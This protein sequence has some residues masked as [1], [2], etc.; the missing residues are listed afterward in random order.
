MSGILDK[1]QLALQTYLCAARALPA[2][3][4]PEAVRAIQNRKL[5]SLLMH[6]YNSTKYYR[7][8]FDNAGVKPT[9]IR[10]AD[11]LP[12]IPPLTR[13]DLRG[14]FWDFLPPELPACRVSRTSGSTGAPVCILSDRNS[15]MFNSAAVIR[16]RR[17]AGIPLIGTPI[18]TPLKTAEQGRKEP[19]WTFL[20]GLH[21][22]YYVN[23]YLDSPSY[24]ESAAKLLTTIRHPVLIGITPAI[25]AL[26]YKVRNKVLPAFQPLA[27]V[28]TGEILSLE[29]R[30]LLESTFT[31]KVFD[32]YSCNE[33]GD[34]AWQ[35]RCGQGYHINADNCIVEILKDGKPAGPGEIGEVVIT[36]LN[37]YSMPIIRY[38]NGDLA[39]LATEPCPCGC[40]LPML[41]EIIG[42]T[43]QD[44]ICPDGKTIAWNQL[45]TPAT[46]PQIRQ[47]QLTQNEDGGLTFSYVPENGS[48]TEQLQSLLAGRYAKLLPPSVKMTF[49][50]A[51]SIPPDPSGK[52]RLVI[53]NYRP[54][55]GPEIS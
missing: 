45:K 10:S 55:L 28:T 19:H 14:R 49:E 41:A 35:C 5:S 48:D 3:F 29:L 46:H 2:P 1:L 16:Y 50:K 30:D 24:A 11:D 31:A 37:R 25:K 6:S 18:L 47:F 8:L 21:K 20:Q 54:P 44:I 9:D 26:A 40:M 51:A 15:R 13:A 32:I 42:R 43:G 52:T 38:K 34:V 23:P 17:A 33:A 7:E 36:N 27:I 39:R 12:C 22:T 53:S 4:R